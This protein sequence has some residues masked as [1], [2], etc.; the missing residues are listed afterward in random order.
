VSKLSPVVPVELT[1]FIANV[2]TQAVTLDWATASETNNRGFEIQKNIGNSWITIAFI[3][4]N[5]TSTSINYYTFTDNYSD[6]SFAGTVTYRLKQFDYDGK[7]N[8]SDEINVTVDFS[9]KEYSL[10]QNFP[11]PF[12][13][14]TTISFSLPKSGLVSLKVFD[15]LGREITTLVNEEKEA[16]KHKVEF[17]ASGLASGVYFYKIT[18]RD[19][20]ATKKLI[21]MK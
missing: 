19:F 11:N 14:V 13:P 2:G 1:S 8:F 7:S 9:A 12:N 3:S 10:S 21:L 17:D 6:N 4:G 20:N 5:G 18:S 16:G 15:N